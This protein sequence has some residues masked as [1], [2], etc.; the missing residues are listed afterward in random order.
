MTVETIFPI[1]V[2]WSTSDK[3]LFASQY[4][5]F[6]SFSILISFSF[7][8]Y[9]FK[10][11]DDQVFQTQIEWEESE[12]KEIRFRASRAKRHLIVKIERDLLIFLWAQSGD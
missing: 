8:K 2:M 10:N 3:K 7:A 1:N 11:I 12:P 4:G 9:H 6:V 5:F